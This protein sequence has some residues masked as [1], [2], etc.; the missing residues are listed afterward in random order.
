M[1]KTE[2]LKA[3]NDN[4]LSCSE[5][6]KNGMIVAFPTETVYG[7]GANGLNE[8]AVNDIFKAKGRPNDN[9]LI[10]HVA[11]I[12][13][14]EELYTDIPRKFYDLAEFFWPA[15]LTIICKK[16]KIVNN[17]VSAGLDTV[18]VR[19][20][21]N[22]IALKLI[23]YS[24]CPIAA[25]SANLSGKPSPTTA[26]HVFH[27]MN[28]KIRAILDGG[29][30]KF[31]VESTVISLIEEPIIL[32]PGCVTPQ[33]IEKVIGHVKI[34]D[35]IISPLKEG[36]K[37]LSPGMKHTHYTPNATVIAFSGNPFEIATKINNEYDN[38]K[39]KKCIILA[40]AENVDYYGN[41]NYEIIGKRTDSVS[42]CNSIFAEFRKYDDYDFIFCEAI[43]PE[44]EGLAYMNRLLRACGFNIK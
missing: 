25:P 34:A 42:F 12:A 24:K 19:M 23:E 17:T 7:L 4:I 35:S 13:D 2:L 11:S 32:R 10:L 8:K 16:S 3:T 20:P 36:E 44:N 37:A 18:A 29:S 5:M 33:M 40:S 30:C 39:T 1:I 31:G 26:Y 28:G 22:K 21:A 9:P 15:P 43:S 41:R 38:N 14:A 6:I 27:D